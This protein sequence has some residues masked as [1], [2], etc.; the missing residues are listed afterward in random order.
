MKLSC[1]IFTLCLYTSQAFSQSYSF[2]VSPLQTQEETQNNMVS[3]LEYAAQ[4]PKGDN[5]YILNGQSGQKLAN[6]KSQ[7]AKRHRA[8]KA[9]NGEELAKL[10]SFAKAAQLPAGRIT[11]SLHIPRIINALAQRPNKT[12]QHVIIQG[13]PLFDEPSEFAVSMAAGLVPSDGHLNVNRL[14]SPLGL[15]GQ[16]NWLKGMQIHW[17]FAPTTTFQNEAHTYAVHRFWTLYFEGM[18]AK[19]VT[20][21]NDTSSILERVQRGAKAL[22]H[23][24]KRSP[25]TKQTMM[26]LQAPEAPDVPQQPNNIPATTNQSTSGINAIGLRWQCE[27]DVDLWVVTHK[28]A[29]PLYYG[30]NQSDIGQL[31]KDLRKAPEMSGGFETI[32]FKKSVNV[33]QL[34]IALNFYGGVAPV[35]GVQG[36]I[37]LTTQGRIITAPFHIKAQTGNKGKDVTR[38]LRTGKITSPHTLLIDPAALIKSWG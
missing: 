31:I 14:Q 24:F 2:V 27:C 10:K 12:G 25:S 7:G 6:F 4:L 15:K 21:G 8:F 32:Q 37:R 29:K 33:A 20:F 19:L 23:P 16:E 17:S 26:R 35:G 30:N 28:D 13:S 18:G 36:E 22:S 9:K 34:K 38:A 1:S 11:G 3:I 5:V